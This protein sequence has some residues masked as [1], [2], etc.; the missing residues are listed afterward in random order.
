MY[1]RD[2][3]PSEQALIWLRFIGPELDTRSVPI[4][5]LGKS[6]IALQSIIQRAYLFHENRPTNSTVLRTRDRLETALQLTSHDKGSDLYGFA[7]LLAD[8]IVQAVI[9]ELVIDSLRALYRYV[10]KAV[11]DHGQS[12]SDTLRRIATEPR[13]TQ[14]LAI[15]IYGDVSILVSRIDNIGGVKA[16]EISAAAELVFLRCN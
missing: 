1:N 14:L 7:P 8:P 12:P 15:N 4:Y 5:E 10:R 3:F 13:D 16:I 11:E 2:E 6:L 9:A